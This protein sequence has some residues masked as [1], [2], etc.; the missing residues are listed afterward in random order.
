MSD[1]EQNKTL[2]LTLYDAVVHREWDRV[3]SLLTDDF[4]DHNPRVA[5][6]LA[7]SDGREA[8]IDYFQKGGTPLDDANVRI[9]R[10]IANEDFAVVHYLLTNPDHPGGLAVVDIF[11]VRDGR[12]SEH[13]DVLQPVPE[14]SLNPHGMI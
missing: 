4:I 5:H 9:G 2:L 12:F 7:A 8:F 14:E 13:W 3:R 10:M 1:A 6:D 11:K